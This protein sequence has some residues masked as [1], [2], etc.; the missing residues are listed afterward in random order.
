MTGLVS[1]Y[2]EGDFM[3]KNRRRFTDEFKAYVVRRHLGDKVPVSDLAAELEVQPS[4]SGRA[5][6]SLRGESFAKC[7]ENNGQRR[8][9]ADNLRRRP[10]GIAR[11]SNCVRYP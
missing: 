1:H 7:R 4:E 9:H 3:S 10:V 6:E 11:G 8:E 5:R 2:Y